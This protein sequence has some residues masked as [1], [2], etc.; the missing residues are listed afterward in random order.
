MSPCLHI[1]VDGCL[2]EQGAEDC[3]DQACDN[4]IFVTLV[5]AVESQVDRDNV[6]VED[7][8]NKIRQP[9]RENKHSK[10]GVDYCVKVYLLLP[11]VFIYLAADACHVHYDE[12]DA[13]REKEDWG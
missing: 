9:G 3:H 12:H 2:D 11:H 10:V 1:N 6:D 5:V 13:D 7:S 4:V 8:R